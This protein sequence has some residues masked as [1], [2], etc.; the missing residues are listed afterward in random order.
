[1]AVADE[2]PPTAGR[3][4]FSSSRGGVTAAGRPVG[5]KPRRG[6]HAVPALT[7]QRSGTG[8]R[9]RK[10]ETLP[11]RG[12]GETTDENNPR[13][14]GEIPRSMQNYFEL[15]EMT[16]LTKY[17][18]CREGGAW[19]ENCSAERTCRKTEPRWVSRVSTSGNGESE[20][21]LKPKQA[22]G[23]NQQ[24]S[25]EKNQQNQKWVLRKRSTELTS[26]VPS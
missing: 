22:E 19:R 5:H 14:E 10:L 18:G 17:V 4:Y 11:T 8:N 1:M 12:V 26:L 3:T 13:V 21:Q 25:V 24:K 9:Q 20:S 16:Q 2:T 6:H 7:P 15:N 23:N